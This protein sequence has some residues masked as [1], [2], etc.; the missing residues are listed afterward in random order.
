MKHEKTESGGGLSLQTLL[1]SS[2][3][4]VIATVVVSQ[5]WESGTLLF[6]ALVPV[7]VALTSEALRRP[8]ERITQ[9]APRAGARPA[10]RR[11]PAPGERDDPFGLYGPAPRR[12]LERRWVRVGLLTG[13]AAFLIGAVVVT[14]SELALFDHSVGSGDR[15][16]TLLG[17]STRDAGEGPEA[18]PEPPASQAPPA[19]G[20]PATPPAAPTP[21]PEAPASPTPTATPPPAATPTPAPA[22]PGEE[23]TPA[24]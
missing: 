6:T 13:L 24:P 22:Q 10:A 20:A 5:F 11:A 15:R 23:A 2:L 17:G 18:I 4:A 21:V 7:A 8:A 9:V 14:A 12:P 16:T 19:P 1:I 3:S